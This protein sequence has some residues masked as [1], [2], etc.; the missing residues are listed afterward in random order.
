MAEASSAGNLSIVSTGASPSRRL[1][2]KILLG[3]EELP[4]LCRFPVSPTSAQTGKTSAL[5]SGIFRETTPIAVTG[6]ERRQ[7]EQVRKNLDEEY[8]KVNGPLNSPK[9]EAPFQIIQQIRDLTRQKSDANDSAAIVE[10]VQRPTMRFVSV[11][12]EEAQADAML[13]R[14]R[15]LFVRQRTQKAP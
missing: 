9:T 7:L 15:A 3:K 8:E 5:Q 4:G 12:P 10:A 13:F 2:K 14:T 11:K 6:F 1:L